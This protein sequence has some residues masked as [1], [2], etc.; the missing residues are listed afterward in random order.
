[1]RFLCFLL[2]V[3]PV[4]ALAEPA[5]IHV[6]VALADNEHQGIVPVP[7]K[8]GK[9][10]D[11]E[12]N[13]YWGCDEALPATLRRSASWK[14]QKTEPGPKASIIERRTYLHASGEWKLV[15]DAYRG[16]AI[17][18]CTVDFFAA[19]GNDEPLATHPLVIYVGHDGLMDF[20][21]PAEALAQRGPGRE[22]IV[23]CCKSE[24]F[25]GASLREINARPLLLTQELMYPGG[26]LVTAALDGWTRHETAAQIL[27]RAAGAYARNQKISVKAATGIFTTSPR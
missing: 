6:F 11:A 17:R 22:A 19:L 7:A 9:G 2:L 21:L 15:A 26:F 16:T 27:Q 25:F 12:R 8:I 18:E 1:M 3:S 24:S 23:F 13:L 10:D 4:L 20:S 5:V 14:L